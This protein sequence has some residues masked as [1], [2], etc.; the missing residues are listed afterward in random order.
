MIYMKEVATTV[1][2]EIVVNVIRLTK[3]SEAC[4]W[5]EHSFPGKRQP[6]LENQ[7]GYDG[8]DEDISIYVV[9]I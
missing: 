6:T 8:H 4:F 5:I 2:D 9:D 3:L 7:S 1:I